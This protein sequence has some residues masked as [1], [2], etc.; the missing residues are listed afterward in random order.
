MRSLVVTAPPVS[1]ATQR[2][3]PVGDECTE[4]H[5]EDHAADH[6]EEGCCR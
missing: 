4:D 1:L 2:E 6:R 3:H 5:A